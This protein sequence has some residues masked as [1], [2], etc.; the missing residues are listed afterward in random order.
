MNLNY[1]KEYL[2]ARKDNITTSDVEELIDEINSYQGTE[3]NINDISKVM[4]VINEYNISF[5]DKVQE[6][7]AYPKKDI[8][9]I[10]AR[11]EK[12]REILCTLSMLHTYIVLSLA[13]IKES[14]YDLKNIRTYMS[15][16][17]E[18]KEHFK[19]EKMTWATILKSLIQEMS[20]TMEMRKMDIEDQ[21]GYM[22]YKDT[23]NG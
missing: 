14:T 6:Y 2:I 5:L 1:V 18:K 16:L 7:E 21:V 9:Q 8:K 3:K 13:S 4:R 23:K 15:E 19:S 11:M 12:I 22:K 20:F 17:H 10:P